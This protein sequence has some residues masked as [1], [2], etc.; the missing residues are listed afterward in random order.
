MHSETDPTITSELLDQLLA[1]SRKPEDLTGEGLEGGA[2]RTRG[3]RIFVKSQSGSA[4]KL[5]EIGNAVADLVDRLAEIANRCE[6]TA[7]M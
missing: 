6:C 5:C 1:S 3:R 2:D 4:G 7:D